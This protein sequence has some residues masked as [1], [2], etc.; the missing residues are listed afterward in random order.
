MGVQA[1]DGPRAVGAGRITCVVSATGEVMP[2]TTTDPAESQGNVRERPLGDIWADGFGDFR[3]AGRG[4][5]SDCDD[6][7]LQT[8]HGHSCRPAFALDLF[9]DGHG[10]VS[11]PLLQVGLRGTDGAGKEVAV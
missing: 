6:C 8:R 2:C 1:G 5:K 7:W 10:F 4:E 3:S 11:G 9:A